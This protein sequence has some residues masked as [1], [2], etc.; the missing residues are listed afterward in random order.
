M[1]SSGL[2]LLLLGVIQ[3]WV[4][5]ERG[6]V[7]LLTAQAQALEVDEPR[8]AFVEDDVLRLEVAVDEVAVRR[9]EVLAELDEMRV[10]AQ[11]GA[12]EAEVSFHEVVDEVFLLPLVGLRREGGREFEVF[13]RTGVEQAVELFEAVRLGLDHIR[14]AVNRLAAQQGPATLSVGCTYGFAHLWLMPRF[15]ALQ[16]LIPGRELRMIT[17]DTRTLFNLAEVDFA[18]RFGRGDWVDGESR[19]LFGERLFPVCSPQ[20]AEAHF[21]GCR[22]V[23]VA[24]VAGAPLIHEREEQ[25]SWLSWQIGRAHV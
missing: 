7:V 17:S 16:K 11:R 2:V 15:S 6:E 9:A 23:D 3:V 25:F 18:L 20:F 22:G 4:V 14:Q 24:A 10:V 1:C 8:L 19:K 5:E 12:V 13:G 21:G